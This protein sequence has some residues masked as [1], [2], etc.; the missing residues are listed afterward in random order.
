MDSQKTFFSSLGSASKSL[1]LEKYL[2]KCGV[3]ASL[4]HCLTRS[5]QWWVVAAVAE[6][7][8]KRARKE[9][10]SKDVEERNDN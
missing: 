7:R 4:F 9:G 8:A 2:D 6:S 5:M 1:S 3:E 10:I